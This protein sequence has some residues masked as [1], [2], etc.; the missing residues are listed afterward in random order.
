LNANVNILLST[1]N[2]EQYLNDLLMSLQRQTHLQTVISVRDDG[3]TDGTFQLLSK[4]KP[5]RSNV[6][7][8]RG[9]RLG[10]ANSFFK[11]LKHADSGCQ[12]FAFCDQDDVWLPEKIEN[13]VSTLARA[14]NGQPLLYCSRIEYV[15]SRLR[16]LGFSRPPTQINFSNAL[17]DNIAAG[18]TIVVN[19]SAR[20]L[21][22]ATIPKHA[23]MHDAWCYLVV[24]A[25]GQVLYDARPSILY[26]Q[27][28]NNALGGTIGNIQL[29]RRRLKRWANGDTQNMGFLAQAREF[30]QCFAQILAK[31]NLRILESFLTSNEHFLQRIAYAARMRVR[32]QTWTDTAI[33]R[34]LIL[35]GR[36]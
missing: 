36:I 3:S 14:E 19:R 23:L 5:N 11:L 35:L 34:A 29:L 13:A 10:A 16:H 31:E 30:H 27:H 21:L 15:D 4:W 12:Y 28:Q 2:G 9:A 26:R 24:S 32:R 6:R 33:L 18:C 1:Y 8:A 20:D 17:V 25:F 7:I 22:A